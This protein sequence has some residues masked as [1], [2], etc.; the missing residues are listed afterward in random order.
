M[1]ADLRYEANNG[2]YATAIGSYNEPVF[3]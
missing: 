1:T 2:E 3:G